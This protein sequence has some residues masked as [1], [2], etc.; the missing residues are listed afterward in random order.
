M[1]YERRRAESGRRERGF[2]EEQIFGT[3]WVGAEV[4]SRGS[5]VEIVEANGLLREEVS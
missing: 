2:G 5:D 4:E 3:F 1:A